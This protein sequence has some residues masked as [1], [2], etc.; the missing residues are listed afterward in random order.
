MDRLEIRLLGGFNALHGS[1]QITKFRS[2]KSRALLAYLATQP[3]QDHPRTRLA[4]LL[5]GNLP[6]KAARTNLR[7]ELSDLKQLLSAH[8]AL[9]ISRTVVRVHHE[10]LTVDAV[11]FRETVTGFLLLPAESQAQQSHTLDAAIELY[12]GE[13][14]AGFQINDAPE[15]EEWQLIVQEQLH[16][17]FM[18]ALSTL[19]RHH[20][21]QSH[22]AELAATARRQLAV[23]P[24]TESAQRNLIHALAAQGEI[25]AAL[26]QYREC[27]RILREELGVEPSLATQDLA[28]RLHDQG[29]VKPSSRHNLARQLKAL[30][31]R[32]EEH[33]RLHDL[34]RR[35]RLVTIFGMG[36]VGKSRLAQAVAQRA[37]R[38][39]ADG[40]W[41]VPLANIEPGESAP[42]Q[43]AL[44]IAG[45]AGLQITD[46]ESPSAE[47]AAYFTGKQVLLVLDNWEHLVEASD[48]ILY[49][50]LHDSDVHI[51][52][53]SRVRLMFENE[54]LVQLSGLSQGHAFSLFVDRAKR[55]LPTFTI[56]NSDVDMIASVNAICRQVDGLPLGIE[57]AASWVEHF[58]VKEIGLSLTEMEAEPKQAERLISRH[59]SLVGVLEYS[60]RLLS[61][62]LQ[63]ILARLSVFR[64]GF[65][66]S[67]ASIVAGSNLHEL[68][69]LLGHSLVQRVA[70]G[71]YDL[72]P[73]VHEFAA[74]KLTPGPA[75]A[76]R[77]RHSRHYLH[78]LVATERAQRSDRLRADFE[79]IRSA[80]QHAVQTG[81]SELIQQAAPQFGEY[82]GQFGLLSD[83]HRLFGDAVEYFAQQPKEARAGCATA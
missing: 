38:D 51:L 20:A 73:L 35:E 29:A 30:I 55:T 3:D 33:A 47:L 40:V 16:Q 65:D 53:T 12:Q 19:Q 57:L 48:A 75:A 18:L 46:V 81:E 23:V 39:F 68:S 63:Q 24:W 31:G 71:R 50:L 27:R 7:I 2:T 70:A 14:L 59:H 11:D 79:N 9:E 76:L 62:P 43:I 44:A 8:P 61:P 13:F 21:E 74:D 67:A 5:W 4:T 66:R 28:D 78:T 72:H 58:S 41:F 56:D 49:P 45:A 15:F 83:G 32:E 60:W 52:A 34:V 22:W 36:G 37:L 1:R 77:L 69:A 64:G 6:E 82:I 42:D 80:W 17:Q 25:N 54:I 10:F 26:T